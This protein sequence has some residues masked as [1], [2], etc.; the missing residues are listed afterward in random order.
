V[1][2]T[3][4]SSGRFPARAATDRGAT[5]SASH[6]DDEIFAARARGAHLKT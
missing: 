3:V 4:A 5:M 2:R 6:F 1:R